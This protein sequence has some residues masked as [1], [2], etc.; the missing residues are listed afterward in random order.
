MLIKYAKI[1]LIFFYTKMKNT[2]VQN[3]IEKSQKETQCVT[4]T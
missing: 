2:T 1:S 3:S 4:I